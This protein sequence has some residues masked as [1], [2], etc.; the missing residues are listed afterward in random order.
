MKIK[1]KIYGQVII[2]SIYNSVYNGIN[3]T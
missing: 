3:Q 2:I 1:L